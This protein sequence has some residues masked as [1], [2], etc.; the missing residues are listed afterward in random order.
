MV[1]IPIQS[2]EKYMTNRRERETTTHNRTTTNTM[3]QLPIPP[4]NRSDYK[5]HF[6]I[7]ATTKDIL[8]KA[9]HHMQL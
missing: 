3:I 5:H 4:T 6:L 1:P 2:S 7:C 8:Q 9:P